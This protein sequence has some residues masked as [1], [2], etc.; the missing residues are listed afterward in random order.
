MRLVASGGPA[1]G[2]TF[3]VDRRLV[4][5]RD[6]A[7]DL[8]LDDEKVSRRHCV[9]LPNPDGTI[10]VEDLGSSNGTHVRGE[11][12]AAPVVLRGGE[13]VRVGSTILRVERAPLE[14]A[15]VVGAPATLPARDVPRP[16]S[17]VPPAEPPAP[18]TPPA[19][20]SQPSGPWWRSRRALIGGVVALLVIG[21]IVGGVLAATGGGDDAPVAVASS[22]EEP[23]ESTTATTG[24]DDEPPPETGVAETGVAETGGVD[25]GVVESDGLTALQ[26]GLLT[27]VPESLQASCQGYEPAAQELLAGRV[28]GL[29]CP[30]SDGITLY[31]DSY[32][33]KESMDAA[34]T[35]AVGDLPR[36]EGDCSSAFPGEGTYTVGDDPG[37]RVVCFRGGDP[38][39]PVIWWTTDEI[40][41]LASAAWE[42]HTDAELYEWWATAPGPNP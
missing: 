36:N 6:E 35:Y 19:P 15:T 28:V 41:V 4:V 30:T 13:E 29:Y 20:A 24:E 3:E 42:G 5:G 34:Y 8:V 38:E 9:F 7:S 2:R 12:I 16:E 18:A 32:D 22:E 14:Q 17:S 33:S 1:S 21:G 10:T 11:R 40:N 27:Y 37:G 23:A 39:A 25:T 31:Y 26:L